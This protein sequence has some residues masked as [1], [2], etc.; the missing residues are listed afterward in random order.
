[1]LCFITQGFTEGPQ[2]LNWK[3][4]LK[5]V[6]RKPDFYLDVDPESGEKKDA[7]WAGLGGGESEDEAEGVEEESEYSEDAG[8][9]SEEEES[10]VRDTFPC[11][12]LIVVTV[13]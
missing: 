5:D 2:P 9:E 7:G 11:C 13:A 4:I 1:M 12:C 8:E 6:V 10:D 3:Q